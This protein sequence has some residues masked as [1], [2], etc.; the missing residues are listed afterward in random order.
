MSISDWSS[1]VCSS[2]LPTPFADQLAAP[3]QDMIAI[4]RQKVRTEQKFDAATTTR[5]FK[6]AASDFGQALFLSSLYSS[7]SSA[8][9]SARVSGV[10]LGHKALIEELESGAVDIAIGGFP[11]LAG[12]IKA[13]TLFRETYVCVM[14]R[15]HPARRTS[16][17]LQAFQDCDHIVVAAHEIGHVHEQVE[18]K[19]LE[20]C[21]PERIR[22]VSESFIVSAMIAE[23]TD[24][25]LTVPGR[26]GRWFAK[27]G[28]LEALGRAQV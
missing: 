4:Y 8:A 22:M 2:D 28:V 7:L 6:V 10:T 3:I 20:I 9:P 26:T 23:E 24:V 13:Q 15:D 16:F 25:V 14:R 18:S 27:R 17:D 12:G 1:D 11:A 5:N 21:P 19:L